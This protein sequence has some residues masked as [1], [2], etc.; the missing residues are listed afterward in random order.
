MAV[1]KVLER[2]N[3]Q[4]SSKI[5]S[6]LS[7]EVFEEVRDEEAATIE[8]EVYGVY[9]PKKYRRRGEHGGLADQRNIQG[10]VQSGVLTVVNRTAP[11]PS[12][13]VNSRLV[14]TDKNL[15]QLVEH[16]DGY[17]SYHYNFP[18]DGSYMEARPFTAKIVENLKKSG[19]HVKA[20]KDG[21]KRR[22]VKV[23]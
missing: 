19:A 3:R 21:L 10:S 11:N 14:T 18:S 17:K 20:L 8:S 7:K 22:G 9:T 5:D 1:Q 15:P 2:I 16:G 23:K 12:G 4:L 13:C 6:A